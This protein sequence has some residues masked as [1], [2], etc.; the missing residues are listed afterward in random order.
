MSNFDLTFLFTLL[1]V[2]EGNYL[3]QVLVCS[4]GVFVDCVRFSC[5]LYVAWRYSL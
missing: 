3:R 2:D 1:E 4:V 5:V